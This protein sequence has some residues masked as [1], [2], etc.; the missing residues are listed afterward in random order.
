MT[1]E[2]ASPIMDVA[3]PLPRPADRC[4]RW[5]AVLNLFKGLLLCALAI[6]LLGFLHK[7]VD[8]IV[9]NWISLLGLNMENRH[10]VAL[11]A[12]LDAVTDRQL[13]HWSGI[14]FALAGVFFTEGAGLFFRRQWA[15]Y[16]TVA[17]TA[18]FIPVEV[19]ESL[20]HFGWAKLALLAINIAVVC[21]LI[22]TLRRERMLTRQFDRP[23]GEPA[24]T[25]GVECGSV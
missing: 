20:R 13:G 6:G 11:L 17:V 24:R 10:I 8:A 23:P 5:I 9:G 15:K 4:L 16:L 2:G 14:T 1:A 21:F 25:T 18:S 12:R 19:T 22:V 7:D 3:A